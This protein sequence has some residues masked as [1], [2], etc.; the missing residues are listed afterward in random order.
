[1]DADESKKV[2]ARDSYMN[3]SSSFFFSSIFV[4]ARWDLPRANI[5]SCIY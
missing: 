1:M 2:T 3:K 5:V 4:L